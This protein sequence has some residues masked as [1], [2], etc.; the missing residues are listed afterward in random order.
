MS[1]VL[2]IERLVIDEALLGGERAD[3]VQ[4]T[5]ERELTRR[6]MHAG[7]VESL[8]GL[9]AVAVLS[10]LPLLPAAHRGE[11]LGARIA[12]AVQGSLGLPG[13]NHGRSVTRH[14]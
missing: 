12:A 9:G 1:I 2:H 14:G 5:I 8:R 13:A 7:A 3:R 6:L 4:A 11:P 10:A